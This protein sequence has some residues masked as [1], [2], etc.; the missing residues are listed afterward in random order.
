M[1][2]HRTPNCLTLFTGNANPKLA[3]AIAQNL[4][5]P[6]SN[7]TLDR[8]NDGEIQC[9]IHDNVR[10]CDVYIIQST[11]PPVNENIMEL[12]VMAD[13]LK[14]ASARRV[15]AV[16]PYFGYARQDRKDKLRVPVTAR[17]V[18]DMLETAG[19]DRVIAVHLHSAQV[20]GFFDI[21]LDHLYTSNTLLEAIDTNTNGY[22]VVSADEGGVKRSRVFAQLLNEAPLAIIDKRRGAPGE[23]Q[24]MHIIGEVKDKHCLISEDMIDTGGTLITA[25]SALKD[26]GAKSISVCASHPVLSKN[27]IEK[28]EQSN[29]DTIIVTDSIPHDERLSNSKT[30][31]VVSLAPL[32]AEAI[33]NVHEGTSISTLFD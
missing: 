7:A 27:A 21:P 23:A 30:F 5:T 2:E 17:L 1:Y 22:T 8:F 19:I 33:K 13:A 9:E 10:D 6:L 4:N 12:L 28:L 16:I 31:K 14:R 3:S 32:L 26:A 24:A 11:C 18:A 15:T 25:A 20:Q 29:I